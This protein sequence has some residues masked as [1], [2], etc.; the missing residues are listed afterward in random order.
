[1]AVAEAK[2]T[3]C[4]IP[5]WVSKHKQ[6]FEYTRNKQ[7]LKNIHDDDDAGDIRII[8]SMMEW[9]GIWHRGKRVQKKKKKKRYITRD[10]IISNPLDTYRQQQHKQMNAFQAW[11][12]SP[13]TVKPTHTHTR[14]IVIDYSSSC[15]AATHT[16][17]IIRN[18]SLHIR[19]P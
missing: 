9:F 7:K 1:M 18:D 15:V 14:A 11:P 19:Q 5:D 12:T 10:C 4:Q 8:H 6:R 16:I 3:I 13:H 2:Y 17:I